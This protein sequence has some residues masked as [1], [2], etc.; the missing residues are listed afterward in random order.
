MVQ[1]L[2][3]LPS[4]QTVQAPHWLVSQP[5]VR[6]GEPQ[7]LAQ[8]LDEQRPRLHVDGVTCSVDLQRDRGHRPPL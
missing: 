7:V 1:L 4:T 2:T 8:K 5:D 3:D 6:A